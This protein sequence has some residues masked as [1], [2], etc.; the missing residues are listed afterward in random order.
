MECFRVSEKWIN[1][2]S[3]FDSKCNIW[4]HTYSVSQEVYSVSL[5]STI[6]I[7]HIILSSQFKDF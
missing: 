7:T 3:Y 6:E 1:L 5:F 4:W 2:G